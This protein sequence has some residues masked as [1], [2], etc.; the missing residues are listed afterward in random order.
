M[1]GESYLKFMSYRI[2]DW[3]STNVTVMIRVSWIQWFV[4]L[5]DDLTMIR[6]VKFSF[7]VVVFAITQSIS[8][9][10]VNTTCEV[11]EEL[12]PCERF[13]KLRVNQFGHTV[14]SMCFM[15]KKSK[16]LTPNYQISTRKFDHVVGII[17]DMNRKIYYLPEKVNKKFPKLRGISA[18]NC[19][20]KSISRANF[21][22]LPTLSALLLSGN[23]ITAITSDTFRDNMNLMFI[24]LSEWNKK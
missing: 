17:F 22:K 9:M 19:S 10:S 24:D 13:K 1:R 18:Q 4:K 14:S 16:I 2:Y 11:S 20:I 12:I 15:D 3:I 6:A 23:K 8:V 7:I 5:S 21:A